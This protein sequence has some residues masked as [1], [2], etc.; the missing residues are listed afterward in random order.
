MKTDTRPASASRAA[1]HFFLVFRGAVPYTMTNLLMQRADTLHAGTTITILAPS[2]WI[3]Y[4]YAA[5]IVQNKLRS[6][7]K[8]TKGDMPTAH[9]SP[10]GKSVD[11]QF[12]HHCSPDAVHRALMFLLE[13]GYSL[14]ETAPTASPSA[15][16]PPV[17]VTDI[18]ALNESQQRSETPL[19]QLRDAV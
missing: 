19:P 13:Q 18:L 14:P 10:N 7:F 12:P 9:Q 16:E 6:L 8:D 5:Q 1:G 17:P 4:K 2:N 15:Q 11:L 3:I